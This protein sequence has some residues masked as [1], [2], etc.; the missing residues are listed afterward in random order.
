MSSPLTVL[1]V[2][3]FVFIGVAGIGLLCVVVLFAIDRLQTQDAIRRNYP[4]IGRFRHI[5]STLGEFFRQYFFAMDREELP[6]NRAQR[7]WVKRTGEPHSNTVAFGSTRNLS[8]VGTPIFVNAA[9]PPLDDQFASSGPMVIG[10]GARMPYTAHSFFNISGMSYG[11]L[12]R[13]A[14]RAL[15]RGA[16]KAGIWMNTGE[17]GLSPFHLEGGCDIVFQIGTAKFGVRD[18][19]GTLN[20][21]KLRKIAANACVKMFELK[22]AQGAKPGKGGILPGAKVTAEIAEIRG[23]K[24]GVD[25][26]S[27]NRHVEIDDWDDLL[28]MIVRLRD[29]T[30][31]PVGIKTVVGDRE[32]FRDLMQTIKK[33][34][35][36]CAPDFITIDGGEGGTGAAPMPL[37]DLV[38][39]SIRESLPLAADLRNEAGLKDRIRLVASGKLVNPG[40]VAWALAAGADFITSARGFMFSLGCIQSLKCNKNTCP[41]GITTHNPRLQKGLVVEDKD[42]RVALYAKEVIHEVEIIAH[43]VG[44]AEPRLL[45]RKHVRIVQNS[46]RSVPMSELYP[47]LHAER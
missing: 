26:I 8:I 25:A 7:D 16:A 10:A 42:Q 34:G 19:D 23:L 37:I 13:P 22:L 21:D 43:S 38:G 18:E 47:G 12:S 3:A 28:D 36:D 20:E 2:L 17:G 39:M 14:V 24:Q 4:V 44:V 1:E 5:F 35:E 46:G 30:G 45:R 6:F 33:R 31:K 41:T 32:S 29:I 15:S 40:D 11:A 9:F 27:P